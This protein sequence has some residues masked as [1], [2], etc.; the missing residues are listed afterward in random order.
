MSS[1]MMVEM[2]GGV[3]VAVVLMLLLAETLARWAT[4]S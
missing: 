3:V 1:H 2:A 4:H